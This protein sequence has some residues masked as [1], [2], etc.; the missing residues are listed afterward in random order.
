MYYNNNRR[1]IH[2]KDKEMFNKNNSD[3]STGNKKVTNLRTVDRHNLSK[4]F[5]FLLN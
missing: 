4:N 2:S 5:I 1:S 3:I